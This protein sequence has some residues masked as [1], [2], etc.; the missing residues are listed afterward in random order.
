MQADFD[1]MQSQAIRFAQEMHKR[2]EKNERKIN[3]NVNNC[4]NTS[5]FSNRNNNRQN[6]GSG[7][8]KS[9]FNSGNIQ[10]NNS[11]DFSLILALMLLLS[12]DSGDKLLMLAL[13]YILT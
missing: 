7:N 3:E 1:K 9:I 6:F 2:A 11:N 8:I 5:D 13:L 12:H 4:H 10:E